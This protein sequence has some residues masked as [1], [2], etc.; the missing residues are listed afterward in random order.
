[1]VT[2]SKATGAIVDQAALWQLPVRPPASSPSSTK[3]LST[4]PVLS[5]EGS[6]L[7]GAVQTLMPMAIISMAIGQTVELAA[8]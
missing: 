3:E 2:T 8:L 6:R 4:M 7:P 1:M 5:L